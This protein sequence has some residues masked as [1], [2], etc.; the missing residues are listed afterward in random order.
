M[1]IQC[2]SSGITFTATRGSSGPSFLTFACMGDKTKVSFS[3]GGKMVCILSA[4]PSKKVLADF[5]MFGT[6]PW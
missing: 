6:I 4:K 2:G 3:T 1:V 5:S